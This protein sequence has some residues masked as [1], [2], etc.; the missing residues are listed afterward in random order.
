MF[1]VSP[2]IP[3]KG[4]LNIPRLTLAK[5]AQW[6]GI[7]GDRKIFIGG[8]LF[9]EIIHGLHEIRCPYPWFEKVS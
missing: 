7:R 3:T 2:N 1:E 4:K 9:T 6:V 8:N 5:L